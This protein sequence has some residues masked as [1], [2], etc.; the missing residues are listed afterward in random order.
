MGS[1]C[2][3]L[4]AM[5]SCLSCCDSAALV[6]SA[7]RRERVFFGKWFA[8]SLVLEGDHK[9]F[10]VVSFI[11]MR[12]MSSLA[13]GTKKVVEAGLWGIGPNGFRSKMEGFGLAAEI[14]NP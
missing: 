1:S 10:S 8:F 12:Y 2:P 11:T 13:E 7:P 5:K 4:D 3:L 9:P 6:V 14:P